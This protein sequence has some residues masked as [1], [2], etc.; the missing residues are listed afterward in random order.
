MSNVH[1]NNG[2]VLVFSWN[3]RTIEVLLD[4]E[5]YWISSLYHNLYFLLKLHV[6]NF[7]FPQKEI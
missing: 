4:K 3:L 5:I 7:D 1:P 6:D 2:R